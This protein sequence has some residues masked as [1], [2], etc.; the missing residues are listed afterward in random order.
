MKLQ[1]QNHNLRI[2]IDEAELAQLLTGDAVDNLTV[3]GPSIQLQQTVRLDEINT[4][5]LQGTAA[6]W[7]VSLP[8]TVV[9]EYAQRL[10]CRE[11]LQFE[12]ALPDDNPSLH[13]R[14]D[15]DVRDSVRQR[16]G[17]KPK[18]HP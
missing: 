6:A 18:P 8:A 15:V 13:L 7:T 4:P 11:G 2:R 5:S 3:L 14:F 17:T 16:L 1:I 9:R 12:L 10:P